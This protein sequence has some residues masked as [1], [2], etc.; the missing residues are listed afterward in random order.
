MR[1]TAAPPAAPAPPPARRRGGGGWGDALPSLRHADEVAPLDAPRLPQPG[2]DRLD[3]GVRV[4]VARV[5]VREAGAVGQAARRAPHAA[6]PP[7][8][9]T[10]PPAARTDTPWLS[11]A[12]TAA[13]ELSTL[14]RP[15]RGTAAF[16][17]PPWA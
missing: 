9:P 4:L 1:S 17:S 2:R 16:A 10:A 7:T 3:D 6:A 15:M 8:P 11:A 13:S 5:L 12:A 14:N